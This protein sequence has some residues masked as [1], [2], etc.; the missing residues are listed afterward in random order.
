MKR[1]T[2]DPIGQADRRRLVIVALGLFFL[3]S[4]LLVQFYD[5]QIEQYDEWAERAQRQHYMVVTEPFRRGTFYSN[6]ELKQG[7]PHDEQ[8]FSTDI[9]KFHLYIDPHN[10]PQEYSEEVA[11]YLVNTFALEGEQ[12]GQLREQFTKRAS[13]S[14]K[15]R[16]WVDPPVKERI[17]D[18]WRPFARE[19]KIPV[20]AVFFVSDYRRSFPFGRLLG[21]VLHTIQENKD[22]ETK[23]GVP[24]GGL[25]AYFD[26][27]L[28]GKLGKRR[29]LRSP[30]SA[31]ATGEVIEK[32]QDGADIYLTVNH[33]LQAIAEEELEVGVKEA[34]AKAGWAVM[35]DPYNGDILALAQYPSFSPADY[36]SYFNDKERVGDTRVRAA[37]DAYEPGSIMKPVTLAIALQANREMAERHQPPIFDPDGKMATADGRFPGRSRPI[38]DTRRHNFLNMDM[39]LQVSSNIYMARVIQRVVERLGNDWYRE[40]LTQHF[41][42]GQ[43][44]SVELPIESV[45]LVPRPG[46]V[47]PNGAL[48]WSVPTP[49]S[50]AM[51]YNLQASGLQ[52]VRAY[53][54]L[55]NG[56]YLVQPSLVKSIVKE[57]HTIWERRHAPK[58]RVLD[59]DIVERVLTAMKYVTK[60]QGSGRYGNLSGFTEAA[61]TGTARKLV[62]G[63]YTNQKHVASII[64]F[65]PVTKPSFVLLV[66][67][68][69]P[70]PIYV[71]GIGDLRHGGVASGPT[72]RRIATRALH[73]LGVSPDDP[74]GFPKGDPRRQEELADWSQE[75]RALREK[76]QLWNGG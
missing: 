22:E 30:R 73:Y 37:T 23:Q 51:G 26:K 24:T 67:I 69:E 32:P 46:R 70:R 50:L 29:L 49:F 39:A 57:G 71:P 74:Y 68:D 5:V 3:F 61:K 6:T 13:R 35:M 17:R 60:G 45:G 28:R 9:L 38:T 21:Q 44:T 48:E 19:R 31:F 27:Y 62:N 18:W 33:I 41:G 1:P 42:F 66:S 2:T 55:A 65:A 76:Y 36:R 63:Q 59:A 25:E 56:G 8:A 34:E 15:L 58:P 52:L 11:D 16:M 47:H 72:F 40:Q 53:S 54:V 12:A 75:S 43:R 10:I 7:H 4:L 64:G 20:N 14:R